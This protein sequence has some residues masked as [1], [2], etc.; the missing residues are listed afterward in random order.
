[1]PEE[2]GIQILNWIPTFFG[3]TDLETYGAYHAPL[4][5]PKQHV[6]AWYVPYFY[7]A[8]ERNLKMH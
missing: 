4:R 7:K 8:I 6:G 2:A 5:T 1:M 3:M